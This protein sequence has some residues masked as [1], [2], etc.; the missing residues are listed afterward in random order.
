MTLDKLL[1]QVRRIAEHRQL[2]AEKQI[3]AAYKRTL[4]DLKKF[5]GYEFAQYAEDGKLTYDILA[6]KQS[7]ARFLEEVQQNIDGLSPET[8]A[9]ILQCVSD[10]YGL[11]YEGMTNA[12]LKTAPKAAADALQ[13]LSFVQPTQVISGVNNELINK[14]TLNDV[15]EK[16]RR[17][18][19]YDLKQ[20][21]TIGIT[22][23]ETVDMMS[24][25]V[26]GV[27]DGD[28]K[29][30]V[31]VVR[32][33]AHRVRE[34]GLSD[35]AKSFDEELQKTDTGLRM[36]KI[37]RTMKDDRVRPNRRYKTKKGWRTSVGSGANHQKMEGQT[38]LAT[39]M[40]ELTD[41]HKTVAPGQSGIAAQDINCRCF[42]QYKLVDNAEFVKLSSKNKFTNEG[43]SGII[44]VGSEEMYRKAKKG[45]IEPMPKKQL[46]RIE[47]SFKR[48]GRTI[49]RS[50]EID[51]YL[52]NKNA[53]AITYNAN[54][55]L[56]RKSPGR[57]S[58]FEEL[59]HA[60]QYKNGENDGSY[61]SRLMCEISAQRKLIDNSK[62]YHLTQIELEQTQKALNAYEKELKKY[63]QGGK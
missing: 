47:K 49:H 36:V 15:L 37:W 20:A 2:G 44:K 53:E 50:V 33:E 24:R 13:G 17:N 18:V 40:F 55:I 11:S 39:D 14:I 23:G 51:E 9:E 25:R 3:R 1:I 19:I 5:I 59:I 54:T 62:A 45:Y 22:N 35:S 31:R 21:V 4:N 6:K 57:A 46:H 58:V 41:G 34:M 32:T 28:Y 56:L 42:V 52:K 48:Q 30:A 29:K 43:N 16:N 38:V 27:L 12:A 60:T 8:Q 63:K 7:T 61:L 10:I 26:S